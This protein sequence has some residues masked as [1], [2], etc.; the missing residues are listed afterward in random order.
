MAPIARIA[1]TGASGYYGANLIKLLRRVAPQA[2][3][4][5]LDTR[6]PRPEA[7]PDESVVVDIR[8]AQ[9]AQRLR[10]FAPDTVVH[11]AFIVNPMHDEREMHDINIGGSRNVCAAVA[12]LKPERFLTAS[13]AT[14]YGAWPDNPVPLTENWPTRARPEFRYAADKAELDAL[15]QQFSQDHPDIAVSWTRPGIIY[16]PGVDNYLSRSI[17]GL[18]VITLVDGVDLPMQFVH[19]E[20]VVAATWAILA[21]SARGPF[22]VAPPDWIHLTELARELGKRT[23]KVP[24]GPMYAIAAMGWKLKIPRLESP[25]GI[26]YFWKWPWVVQPRRLTEELGYTFKYSSRDTLRE[27]VRTH[28]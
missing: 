6:P 11:L 24:F 1:I 16:G 7:L 4:L 19:E 18:P 26:L 17:L 15:L 22:N 9:V 28:K 27:M 13:S 23:L 10:A 20:D 8:D 5:G 12:E 3:I 21:A 25:P 2:R 14:A